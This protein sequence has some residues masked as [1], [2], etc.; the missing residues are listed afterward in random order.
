MELGA[1][2][3]KGGLLTLSRA[4]SGGERGRGKGRREVRVS[5]YVVG[6][7]KLT[8][9]TRRD[10]AGG[11]D[12]LKRD[13]RGFTVTLSCTQHGRRGG[14]RIIKAGGRERERERVEEEE[15]GG[16]GNFTASHQD[17]RGRSGTC[18]FIPSS[19]SHANKTA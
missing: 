6:E 4:L 2:P 19:L 18:V 13:D 14:Y 11:G 3:R 7:N 17:D 10:K 15:A 5:V 12:A 1:G 8:W 9:K 16:G